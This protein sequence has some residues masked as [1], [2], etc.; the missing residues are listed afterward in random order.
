M[1][2]TC[3]FPGAP[4]NACIQASKVADVAGLDSIKETAEG[5]NNNGVA[6]IRAYLSCLHL[7]DSRPTYVLRF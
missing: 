4:S 5:A 2:Q 3:P 7:L 1:P 6:L